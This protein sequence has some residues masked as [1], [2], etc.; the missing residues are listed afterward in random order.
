MNFPPQ[1]VG[2]LEREVASLLFQLPARAAFLGKRM[3]DGAVADG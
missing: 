2:H 3:V 1:P